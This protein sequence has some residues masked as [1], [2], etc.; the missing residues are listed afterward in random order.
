MPGAA[1]SCW[2]ANQSAFEPTRAFRWRYALTR[3]PTLT[4][5]PERGSCLRR[6][7]PG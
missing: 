3:G 1:R 4:K 7:A 5:A 6:A 2:S